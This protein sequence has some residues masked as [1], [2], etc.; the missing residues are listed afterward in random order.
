M[1]APFKRLHN[2]NFEVEISPEMGGSIVNVS[3]QGFS[4]LRP[5][6]GEATVRKTASYP[7]VPFSNRI[8]EGRFSFEGKS[9]QLVKNFGDHP[10]TIHGVGWER[11][12]DY[13]QCSETEALLSLVHIP[14]ISDDQT[15]YDWPFAFKVT[16]QITLS[17]HTLRVTMCFTNLAE[18]NAP[19]GLGWH[20]FF[21]R[22]NGVNLTTHVEKVW[23]NDARMLPASLEPV[24]EIWDFSKSKKVDYVGSDNCYSGWQGKAIIE[25]PD[26]GR[27]VTLT[28][29]PNMTHLVFFTP[30]SPADFIAV[31]PVTNAND[32]L[33]KEN[34]KLHGMHIL[35]P[36]ES[37]TVFMELQVEKK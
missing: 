25:W 32:A 22:N 11:A 4:I 8:A 2:A 23:L 24:P 29:S 13:S 35:A 19:V 10:H 36:N 17:E 37:L 30:P 6:N 7:L 1:T 34:P 33:N 16:E 3:H 12:W 21:P 27:R 28:A 5:W 15:T 18:C 20:P 26:E 14:Q 31:E 9:Y